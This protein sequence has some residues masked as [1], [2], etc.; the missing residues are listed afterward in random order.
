VVIG[1]PAHAG[2]GLTEAIL[3]GAEYHGGQR[4]EDRFAIAS[5]LLREREPVVAYLYVDELDRAA[6]EHGWQG[7]AWVRRLEALDA[8]L[9]DL[10]M[11]LPGDAGVVVTADHGII[12]V[13]AERQV[14]LDADPSLIEGVA[15]IG[16]NRASGRSISKTGSSLQPSQRSGPRPSGI[17][18]GSPPGTRPSPVEHSAR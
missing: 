18:R 13:P 15:Q 3:R 16:E 11:T 2:G 10:L 7:E 14:M 9:A 12:D 8:A 5:T 1:R 6:H 4:I 17:V